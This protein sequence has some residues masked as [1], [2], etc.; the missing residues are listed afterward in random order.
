MV[1]RQD[2]AHSVRDALANLYDFPRLETHPLASL[3]MS[4][5]GA[6]T[7]GQR[8]R[9]L[10]VD[11]IEL[12][13]PDRRSSPDDASWLGYRILRQRYIEGANPSQ[14]C[15]ALGISQATF[16]RYHRRALDAVVEILWQRYAATPTDEPVE[17]TLYTKDGTRT[18]TE[19]TIDFAI[20]SEWETVDLVKVA[21][22]VQATLLPLAKQEGVQ[23]HFQLPGSLP[24][25]YGS[26]VVFRQILLH[27]LLDSLALACNN[28]LTLEVTACDKGSHW[29]LGELSTDTLGEFDMTDPPGLEACRELLHL[30]GGELRIDQVSE[31]VAHLCFV[32]PAQRIPTVLIVED[33]QE[34]VRLYRTYLAQRDYH[35]HVAHNAASVEAHVKESLPDII[36]TDVIM[37]NED[38]WLLLQRLK[39]MPETA[40]IPVVV[41]SVLDQPQLALSLG[42]QRVLQK[43]ISQELLLQTIDSLI[44]R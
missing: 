16:Y 21:Q 9:E 44:D 11:T 43:P 2:F 31:R 29:R 37:P 23:V 30:Y 32:I 17:S 39:T 34:I 36:L 38:G 5:A 20:S 13:Q 22:S 25:A 41:C 19:S 6:G 12:L 7:S 14:I 42:A 3:G 26:A 33:D 18:P 15:S 35:I 1:T 28:L 24:L 40:Q 27:A 10:L 4:V 8:L